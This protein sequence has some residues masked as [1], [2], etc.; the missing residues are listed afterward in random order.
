MSFF[1]DNIILYIDNRKYSIRTNQQTSG[2]DG[3]VGKFGSPLCT[4]T[5]KLQ[6][7]YRTIAQNHQKIEQ[8]GSPTNNELKKPNSPKQVGRAEGQKGR[9]VETWNGLVPHPHV[10]DINR[11]DISGEVPAPKE[12]TQ[13]RVLVPGRSAIHNFWM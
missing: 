7:N 5:A 9:D 3:G 2:Q 13:P 12:T 1:A 11:R 4:T 6:K 8:H 10:V